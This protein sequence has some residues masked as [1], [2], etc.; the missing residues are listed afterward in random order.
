MTTKPTVTTSTPPGFIVLPDAPM[1]EDM[2]NFTAL[3]FPGN[4]HFLAEH[5]GNPD[6]TLII[7]EA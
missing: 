6:T 1:P 3:H 5:L 4:T 7:G 2:N